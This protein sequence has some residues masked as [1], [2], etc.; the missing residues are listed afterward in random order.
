MTARILALFPEQLDVNGDAQNALVLAQR[1]RWAGLEAE[2]VPVSVGGQLPD[3]T[4]AAIVVGSSVDADLSLL[5]TALRAFAPELRDWVAQG[6]PLLAVGTGLELLAEGIRLADGSE[7]E[8]VGVLPGVASPLEARAA[9]DLVVDSAFGRLIGYENHARGLVLPTSADPLGDVVHGTGNG[10]R[11]EGVR[12]DWAIGTRLHGPVLAKNPALADAILGQA[13][14]GS[15]S[16]AAAPL[17]EVDDMARA[18]REVIARR[19]G[20]EPGV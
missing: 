1:A 15:Y 3:G 11:T 4:P 14:G 19:L 5:S 2:V 12:V 7:I 8:G 18:A 13:F 17:R 20:L 6:I 16:A 9:D 10:S